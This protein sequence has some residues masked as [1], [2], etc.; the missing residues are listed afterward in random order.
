MGRDSNRRSLR[1]RSNLLLIV[2]AGSLKNLLYLINLIA[3]ICPDFFGKQSH[4]HDV[5]TKRLLRQQ[6]H[7]LKIRF[8]HVPR[9]DAA[10]VRFAWGR[11]AAIVGVYVNSLMSARPVPLASLLNRP[12]PIVTTIFPFA[13]PEAR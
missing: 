2:I 7:L 12:Y 3:T 11:I 9:N 5:I 8:P 6:D 1:I 10:V 4:I 13:L